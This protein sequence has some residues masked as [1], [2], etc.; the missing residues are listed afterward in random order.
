MNRSSGSTEERVP[1]VDPLGE[2]SEHPLPSADFSASMIGA[3]SRH[4]L[5]LEDS[6]SDTAASNPVARDLAEDEQHNCGQMT[7]SHWQQA[8]QERHRRTEIEAALAEER[9]KIDRLDVQLQDTQESLAR[10]GDSTAELGQI[11]RSTLL[12]ASTDPDKDD[13]LQSVRESREREGTTEYDHGSIPC[14]L[15]TTTMGAAREPARRALFTGSEHFTRGI[16]IEALRKLADQVEGRS[17]RESWDE[18]WAAATVAPGWTVSK[19]QD[20]RTQWCWDYQR[21]STG[22]IFRKS[23]QKHA[24]SECLSGCRAVADLLEEPTVG[25][26]FGKPTHFVS[27]PW[28]MPFRDLLD[29]LTLAVKSYTDGTAYLWIDVLLLNYHEWVGVE[30]TDFFL[31]D[32]QQAIGSIGRIIQACTKWSAPE[33]LNRAWMMLESFTAVAMNAELQIAMTALERRA[34]ANTLHT[35]G[36][37]AVLDVVFHLEG[38]PAKA[39]AQSDADRDLLLPWLE[40]IAEKVGGKDAMRTKLAELTR[41][42]YAKAIDAEFEQ[43][44]AAAGLDSPDAE[45]HRTWTTY[46]EWERWEKEEIRN[47]KANKYRDPVTSAAMQRKLD[48]YDLGHQLA[49]LWALT[50]N[51]ERAEEIFERVISRLDVSAASDGRQVFN[52]FGNWARRD[53]TSAELVKLLNVLNRVPDAHKIERQASPTGQ[54]AV[55]WNGVSVSFLEQFA[56]EYRDELEFLSTDATVER[57][58]KPR[59]KTTQMFDPSPKGVAL[60]ETVHNSLKGRPD[61]FLTHAWRQTF[62]VPQSCPWRGGIV[63]AVIDSFGPADREDT[64]FWFDIFTVNQHQT[65][66]AFAFEPLRNAIIECDHIKMFMETWDD[67]APLSRVWCL[68]ELKNALLLGKEVQICM[69]KQARENFE[70]IAQDDPDAAKRTIKRVCG[71]VDIRHA[72]ATHDR[73]RKQVLDKVKRT[74][75]QDFLNEV[76]REI[77]QKALLS[78]ANLQLDDPDKASRWCKIFT[79]RLEKANDASTPVPQQIEIKRAVAMMRRRIFSRDTCPDE[80]QSGTELL[81][82]V[83]RLAERYYG[84]KSQ[85]VRDITRQLSSG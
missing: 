20:D 50:D 36:P 57:I 25:F 44:W 46:D 31:Y 17:T 19:V 7:R 66:L 27:F 1:P 58:I 85:L 67:P 49:C 83:A 65:A 21:E 52:V 33:R 81:D 70:K 51:A 35:N 54:L 4:C 40:A 30:I 61:F 5:R 10:L 6:A 48:V 71:R 8:E 15:S 80:Y 69:P 42:A 23:F 29:A 14:R 26:Y 73:D 53:K 43:Q 13:L 39:G 72:S 38:D 60:I 78:A 16:S 9:L 76:C 18:I 45:V 24:P 55:S 62:Y 63:Q 28:D 12:C 22:D 75:G 74:I 68:D 56:K 77:I 84:N 79:E 2:I 32:V 37:N 41:R 11:R 47:R 59:T 82:E 3:D 64:H 34:I